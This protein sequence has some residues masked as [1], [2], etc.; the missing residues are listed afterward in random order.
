MIPAPFGEQVTAPSDA[1]Y[2]IERLRRRLAAIPEVS[3][4]EDESVNIS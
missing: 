1:L 3:A 2:E 4:A